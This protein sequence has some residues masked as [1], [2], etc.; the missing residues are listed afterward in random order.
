MEPTYY[1]YKEVPFWG[2]MYWTGDFVMGL[3]HG[4]WCVPQAVIDQQNIE[5]KACVDRSLW[6]TENLDDVDT[7][8]RKI[9]KAF[10]KLIPDYRTVGHCTYEALPQGT[11]SAPV[12]ADK[13]PAMEE[14]PEFED[15]GEEWDGERYK[16]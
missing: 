15:R 11:Y 9:L 2:R 12:E 4:Q 8:V 5:G 3:G 10:P 1:I 14:T 7:E 13:I 6:N 16:K